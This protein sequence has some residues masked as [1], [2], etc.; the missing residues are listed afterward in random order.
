MVRFL[1]AWLVL[2]I[3]SAAAQER[4]DLPSRPG[5]TEPIYL[6]TVANPRASVILF[7]GGIGL[8]AKVRANFLLRVAPRFVAAGM[9]V[10]VF[11]SPSDHPN[12]IGPPFRSTPQH[13]AD[14]AAAVALLKSRSPAPVWLI[15]T[16]NGSIS[17]AEGAA[18]V[19]PPKVAGVVLTS[20]VWEG[21][22]LS[23]PL[24]QIS[25]PVLVVHNR[26]DG[27]RVS[28][29]GE[30]AS[31]MALMRQAPT[32]EL[33]TVSGGSLRGDPC[34]AMSQH[35]YLGIEDQVVPAII[36]WIEGH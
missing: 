12:G 15:G 7:P 4:V 22:M 29:Y 23:V 31:S 24:G 20:S 18:T 35:G 6:T 30:T 13:A 26:D 33:L 1:V 3:G 25:V 34:E 19:G 8:V 16:S 28:P 17:A 27:C 10:A 2:L 14:I 36:A 32:K 5:V 21:G 9:T 11:D